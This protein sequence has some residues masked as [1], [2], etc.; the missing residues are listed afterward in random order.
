MTYSTVDGAVESV[1][2]FASNSTAGGV[3]LNEQNLRRSNPSWI[4]NSIFPLWL[5]HSGFAGFYCFG[6]G[7][8]GNVVDVLAVHGVN[9]L[10]GTDRVNEVIEVFETH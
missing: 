10:V 2:E 3:V 8:I 1:Q 7:S 6:R 5:W 9:T 4:W